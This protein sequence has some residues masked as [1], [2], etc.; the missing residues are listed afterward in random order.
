MLCHEGKSLPGET[1]GRADRPDRGVLHGRVLY[2]PGD[3]DTRGETFY[4]RSG[5]EKRRYLEDPGSLPGKKSLQCRIPQSVFRYGAVER[6]EQ[7][8]GFSLSQACGGQSVRHGGKS[9]TQAYQKQ[10]CLA[11]CKDPRDPLFFRN[12]EKAREDGKGTGI[13]GPFSGRAGRRLWLF[14]RG[15]GIWAGAFCVLFSGTGEPDFRGS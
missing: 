11:L 2:L 13:P 12:F 3:G 10:R 5:E 1:D 9:H 14:R 4:L 6:G 8:A 15:T 7:K